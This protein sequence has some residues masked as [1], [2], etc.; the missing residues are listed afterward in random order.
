MKISIQVNGQLGITIWILM[1][2]REKKGG[3]GRLK[4]NIVR[5]HSVGHKVVMS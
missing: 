4:V 5:S 1:M 3:G 2:E